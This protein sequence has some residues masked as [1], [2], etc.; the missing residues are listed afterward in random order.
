M[1]GHIKILV[2]KALGP[3]ITA[4]IALV[5]DVLDVIAFD[6]HG[7][8]TTVTRR[9]GHSSAGS[10]GE[11]TSFAD[12][13]QSQAYQLYEIE[14]NSEYMS[15]YLNGVNRRTF[16]RT[17][18]QSGQSQFPQTPMKLK[19]G[20]W[21][22]NTTDGPDRTGWWRGQINWDKGPHSMFV[23]S[24]EIVDYSTG[25]FYSYTD[26]T[27]NLNS[28][29]STGGSIN[30]NA[31]YDILGSDMFPLKRKGIRKNDGVPFSPEPLPTAPT[32]CSKLR[33]PK[34]DLYFGYARS[35]DSDFSDE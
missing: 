29:K 21:Y 25:Q 1:F 13:A 3:G 16:L 28:I 10:S 35:M 12:P 7:T 20:T 30:G 8:N 22:W 14:W 4:S 2:K 31:V 32:S 15:W 27:G 34:P 24:V 26:R 17:D 33:S 23:Q 9:R 5:S 6:L 19:I 18:V 11:D